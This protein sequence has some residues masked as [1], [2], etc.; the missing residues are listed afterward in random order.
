MLGPLHDEAADA[1]GRLAEDDQPRRVLHEQ[2][3]SPRDED[4]HER[5]GAMVHETPHDEPIPRRR[6]CLPSHSSQRTCQTM[7]NAAAMNNYRGAGPTR[8]AQDRDEDCNDD[9]GNR[10][11]RFA[12]WRR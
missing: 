12:M 8:G 5:I 6:A 10:A 4:R 2:L 11:V 7:A 3:G 9:E 1:G